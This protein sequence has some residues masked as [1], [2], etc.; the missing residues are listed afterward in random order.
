MLANHPNPN[1]AAELGDR[2]GI[3]VSDCIGCLLLV[4]LACSVQGCICKPFSIRYTSAS[5]AILISMR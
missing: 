5:A 1:L 3:Y 4:R 2:F